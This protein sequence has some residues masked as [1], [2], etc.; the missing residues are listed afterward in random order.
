MNKKLTKLAKLSLALALM[1]MFGISGWGQVPDF[2]GTYAIANNNGYSPSNSTNNW[3][4]VPAGE[5][6]RDD[7]ADAF[8]SPDYYFENGDSEKPFLTT[9]KTKKDEKSIWYIAS[10]GDG[11]GSYYIQHVLTRK[12]VT[13][14]VVCEDHPERKPLHFVTT[15][16]ENSKFIITSSNGTTGGNINIRPK[17]ITS[18]NMY[19]NPLNNNSLRYNASDYND[20][21][22]G[23]HCYKGLIGLYSQN[24]NDSYWHFEEIILPPSITYH[25]KSGYVVME[26]LTP[27]VSIYYNTNSDNDPNTGSTPYTDSIYCNTPNT[28]FKAIAV[29]NGINS[30]TVTFE[31]KKVATPRVV[32]NGDYAVAIECETPSAKRYYTYDGSTPTIEDGIQYLGPNYELSGYEIIAIAAKENMITSDPCEP[33]TI[34]LQTKPPVINLNFATGLVSIS[35]NDSWATIYYSTTGNDPDPFQDGHL[36]NDPF[37]I[38][39]GTTVKAMAFNDYG[40]Y[41][42]SEIVSKTFSQV[43]APVITKNDATNSIEITCSTVGASIYYTTDGS[44]PGSSSTLY[45]RPLL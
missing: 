41:D 16:T 22:A 38:E 33:T 24:I 4:L 44:E 3:Y 7:K 43:S 39:S 9:Y 32:D 40:Y 21:S 13:Y 27:G 26:S 2:T 19:F 10:T 30:E 31:L 8:Y 35:C 1:T 29:K 23:V 18:G 34:T 36:Y 25:N 12:Y 20:A 28:I 15:P 6:Q 37:A 17:S 5:S 14:Q 11:D 45:T 42:L